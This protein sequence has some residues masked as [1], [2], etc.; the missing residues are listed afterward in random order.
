M[1]TGLTTH[2]LPAAAAAR[3][4]R[5]PPVGVLFAALLGYNPIRSLLAP[6][7]ILAR[8]PAPTVASLTSRSFFPSL[9][10]HPFASGL[11]GAFAFSV[12]AT[13]VAAVASWLRGGKYHPAQAQPGRVQP[14]AAPAVP[15]PAAPAAPARVSAE[16]CLDDLADDLARQVGRL[17]EQAIRADN[18]RL[19]VAISGGY[20]AGGAVLG[21]IVAGR[22][23]LPFLDRSI[24][25]G[26][27]EALLMPVP[28]AV[29]HDDRS[30]AGIERLIS[31]MAR[32]STL[33]G[34]G[35][36]QRD[37]AL[38]D[39]RIFQLA[40]ELVLWQM[41]AQTGG[42]VLGRAATVVLATHPGVLRVRLDAPVE[43]RIYQAV[44]YDGFDL[45]TARR[46]QVQTDR[47]RDAYTHHFYGVHPGDRRLY[48]LMIDVS[49][50]G[51]AVSEEMI[52]LAA[53]ARRR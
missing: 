21:P 49:R 45:A 32:S 20:G 40:T 26:V 48:D 51:Y 19:V 41:A 15:A 24:P 16:P 29:G 42:V 37:D 10:A 39:E 11:R 6:T 44:A 38:C 1:L 18:P 13:V 53:G 3:V 52:V 8:L 4:A 30:E 27:A 5:Q 35:V 2:G 25:A 9:I 36:L 34:I 22:L 43:R 14:A 17:R 33:Y 50:F 31:T 47:A 46:V 23:G 28:T 7:G 12:A